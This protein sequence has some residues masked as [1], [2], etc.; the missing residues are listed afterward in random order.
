MA[1]DSGNNRNRARQTRYAAY[2]VLYTLVVIAAAVVVNVLANR[3]SKSWDATPNKRYTLSEETAKIVKGLKQDATIVFFDQSTHFGEAR[4]LLDEYKNLSPKVHVQYVD[5]DKDPQLTRADGVQNNGTAVVQIGDKKEAAT[6][7]TEEGIT[8]AF[9]RDLKSSTRTICF[10]GGSGEHQIDD[11][12]RYGLSSFKDQLA[13]ES[14][15]TESIDLIT[16]PQVSAECTVLVIAGPSHDYQQPEVSAIQD[17]VQ[18]GGRT[19]FLLDPPLQG[20]TQSIGANDALAAVLTG[21]GVTPDTDLILDRSPIGQLIGVGPEVALV[22]HYEQQ[23]I[24]S[25]LKGTA[26]G[27]PIAQSISISNSGK[28]SVDKMFESS[29]ASEAATNLGGG[30][31]RVD[32]PKNKRGPLTM[33][34]AGTYTTGSSATQGRF[35]VLGSSTWLTNAFLDFNG[36]SDL[37]LNSINWLASDEDLISIHPKAPEDQ[38]MSLT[39]AQMNVVRITSQFVLPLLMIV[40]GTVIWWRRR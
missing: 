25:D 32:D 29:E 33:A 21:W 19:M 17:Y 5:P 3:Y 34:A 7:L 1:S 4:D 6:A 35:V 14:Y 31:L 13:K 40:L 11:T 9:I 20:R 23:P 36:N 26:T 24:V 15:E 2:A 12:G 37:A 22:T 8:G 28:T 30:E 16:K 27:F 10:A 39:R 18:K 38:H